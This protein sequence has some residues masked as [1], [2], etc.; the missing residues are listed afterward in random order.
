MEF[1]KA[2]E[3]LLQKWESLPQDFRQKY[4]TYRSKHLAGREKI[5]PGKKIEMLRE[6]GYRDSWTEKG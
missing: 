6:A 1:E 4:V 2:F 5:G 3:K